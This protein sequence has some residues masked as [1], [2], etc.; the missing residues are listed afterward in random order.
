MNLCPKS[1]LLSKSSCY[2]VL[3]CLNTLS[4]SVDDISFVPSM[5]LKFKV[6]I[7]LNYYSSKLLLPFRTLLIKLTIN[8]YN[9]WMHGVDLAD[10]YINAHLPRHKTLS[11]K[12]AM[13]QGLLF[14]S[15]LSS[16][17]QLLVNPF[18]YHII[19]GNSMAA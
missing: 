3:S 12:R 9:H 19:H 13:F 6:M 10:R 18:C 17:H 11:W 7:K 4:S 8:D 14:R 1:P 5:L 15:K 16:T 2:V